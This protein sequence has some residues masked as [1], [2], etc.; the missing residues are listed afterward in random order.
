MRPLTW[1][2]SSRNFKK[3]TIYLFI[4]LFVR[5]CFYLQFNIPRAPYTGARG[6]V[7]ERFSEQGGVQ[8]RSSVAASGAEK[9]SS[10]N[11]SSPACVCPPRWNSDRRSHIW[12]EGNADPR[13]EKQPE[14]SQQRCVQVADPPNDVA[15]FCAFL[16]LDLSFVLV[17][18]VLVF[19]ARVAFQIAAVGDLVSGARLLIICCS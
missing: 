6:R 11:V 10:K 5:L 2:Y 19:L 1:W 12:L 4:W 15:I 9:R 16:E 18:L 14:G 13:I 17:A 8:C 3:T 7:R